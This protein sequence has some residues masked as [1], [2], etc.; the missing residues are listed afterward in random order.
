VSTPSELIAAAVEAACDVDHAIPYRPARL[1]SKMAFVTA[2]DPWKS[3]DDTTFCG[4]SFALEVWLVGG[5]SDQQSALS[6]LDEQSTILLLH[7][8]IDV[9]DDSVMVETVDPPL[10][11]TT[12]DGS[13]FLACRVTY[14]RFTTGG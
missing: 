2:G 4:F 11:F 10:V 3:L 7:S 9:G 8:P 1:D 6:W 5:S 12:S 14:S 13:S